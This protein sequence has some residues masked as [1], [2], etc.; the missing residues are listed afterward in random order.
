MPVNS[1]VSECGCSNSK[2]MQEKLK[3]VTAETDWRVNADAI[4]GEVR[5]SGLASTETGGQRMLRVT[6]AKGDAHVHRASDATWT[7]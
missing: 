7:S 2:F 1:S 3:A 6:V 4:G 5:S